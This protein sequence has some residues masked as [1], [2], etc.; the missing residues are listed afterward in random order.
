MLLLRFPPARKCPVGT[1]ESF[2]CGFGEFCSNLHRSD[3]EGVTPCP[4]SKP[5][6]GGQGREEWGARTL[7]SSRNPI[8]SLNDLNPI[9]SAGPYGAL[10][11]WPNAARTLPHRPMPPPGRW[12][13]V[14]PLPEGSRSFRYN[15]D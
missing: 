13:H 7:P 4:S 5:W 9:G 11:P 8:S 3:S 6:V 2:L 10:C 14:G 15:T 12:G 1:F